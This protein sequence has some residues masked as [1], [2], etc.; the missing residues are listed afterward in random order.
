MT[1]QT[2]TMQQV[3]AN[4]ERLAD[5]KLEGPRT[6]ASALDHV[7]AGIACS[8][9]GYP[10]HKPWIFQVTIG[11]LAL[12]KFL[13]D[14]RMRHDLA[15]V[16]PGVPQDQDVAFGTALE[17]LRVQWARFEAYQGPMAPHFAYGP[18]DK[19]QYAAVHVM[20]LQ[21]HLGAVWEEVVG[22]KR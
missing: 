10:Q 16:I 14:G 21:D 11:R 7:A 2:A 1:P 18:V 8:L 4:L 3:L 17:R 15:A 13:R 20:H 9:D 6:L 19:G 5:R 22:A 12:G